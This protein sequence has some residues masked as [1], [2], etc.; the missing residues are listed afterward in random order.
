M[1]TSDHIVRDHKPVTLLGGGEVFGGDIGAALTLAP[2]CVAADSGAAL[3]LA[4]GVELAAVIGDFDSAPA[5]VLARIPSERCHRIAEQESTDFDKALTR[6]DAP[7]VLGVGFTGARLD[8]Q[9]AAFNTLATYPD[10]PCI[11]LGAH[12]IVLLAP[13]RITLPTEAG[14]VVS[15]MPLAPV[16]GRSRGLEW[17]IDGL[18]FAPGGRVGTSNRA[19][20]P[21]ALEMDGPDMLLI[22]PRRLM[23]PLAAQLLRPDHAPWPARA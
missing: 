17:P 4:A 19:L 16:M 2:T 3:A 11:L 20:G 15:L 23:A 14:D 21:V 13:P 18:D 22:L 1:T 8:H 10:R 7:L 9:L 12:E 5:E 6:I